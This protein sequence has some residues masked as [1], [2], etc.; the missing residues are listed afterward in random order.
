MT[1]RYIPA[2]ATVGTYKIEGGAWQEG[3]L[4]VGVPGQLSVLSQDKKDTVTYQAKQVKA[5]VT[6]QD[7][8]EVLRNLKVKKGNLEAVFAHRLYKYGQ[9][10]AFKVPRRLILFGEPSVNGI[11]ASVFELV[12]QSTTG[13][14]VVV[15]I[16]RR[17]FIE[18]MLPLV[19]DCPE[20]ATQISKGKLWRE[21]M[22]KILRTY[23][24]WQQA[25]P[26]SAVN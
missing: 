20:L 17:A 14:A 16:G 1:Y 10:T 26:Q 19:G 3:L 12:V 11:P 8:F 5:Y 9:L 22:R 6:G 24:Y 21:D 23:A 15:P 18:A 25:N 7:T 2:P 13:D 4:Y